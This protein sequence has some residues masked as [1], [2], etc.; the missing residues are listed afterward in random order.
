MFA[1]Q[2]AR[3]VEIMI[4]K[5]D[6]R[7]GKQSSSMCDIH[8]S[9]SQYDIRYA[10][11]PKQVECPHNSMTAALKYNAEAARRVSRLTHIVR[12]ARI[13]WQALRRTPPKKAQKSNHRAHNLP[14][15]RH[16]ILLP[17]KLDRCA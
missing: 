17:Q 15:L 9:L 6:V 5:M 14:R 7:G 12:D 3:S 11:A 16:T 4:V 2:L 1:R 13:M 8:K 10:K